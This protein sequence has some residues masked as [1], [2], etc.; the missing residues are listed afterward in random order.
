MKDVCGE[1]YEKVV[2]TKSFARGAALSAFRNPILAVVELSAG[3]SPEISANLR[4]FATA[5][6]F[7]A[8]G[9]AYGLGR[10]YLQKKMG[11]E[12]CSTE[13]TKLWF[14]RLYGA[15][16]S[17]V[18]LTITYGL[19]KFFG[20]QNML[21]AGIPT[22]AS[23]ALTALAGNGMGRTIDTFKDGLGL[24]SS[25]GRSYFSSE[26]PKEKKKKYV[27]LVNIVSLGGLAAYYF[28]AR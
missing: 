16:C 10:S 24:E 21:E 23:V 2:R 4:M 15:S 18:E 17:L 6:N 27:D 11:I 26:M 22:I 14:D 20:A 8:T 1:I 5:T 19:Y 3:L 25:V 9:Q 7:F 12:A 13:E 28:V